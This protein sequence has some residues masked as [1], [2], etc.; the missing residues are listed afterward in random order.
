MKS[1]IPEV[2]GSIIGSKCFTAETAAGGTLVLGFEKVGNAG[3][4]GSSHWRFQT[5][6]CSWRIMYNDKILCGSGDEEIHIE[7]FLQKLIGEK[8]I[9][10]ERISPFDIVFIFMGGME[11]QL[12]SQ[13]K[14]RDCFN[15]LSPEESCITF[16][17]AGGWFE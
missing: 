16:S 1:K 8:L 7:G 4:C 14:G 9:S 15:I 17:P 3:C 6:T 11:I 12:L 10:I 13:S 2:L 5:E